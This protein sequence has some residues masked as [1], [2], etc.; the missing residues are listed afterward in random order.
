MSKDL[1]TAII[2]AAQDFG[3]KVLA[4]VRKAQKEPAQAWGV[5]KG[6]SAQINIKVR[7]EIRERL[8]A[9]SEADGVSIQDWFEQLVSALP[10]TGKAVPKP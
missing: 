6:R 5:R 2:T 7:P 4:A 9:F 3:A 8:F 1:E 10:E